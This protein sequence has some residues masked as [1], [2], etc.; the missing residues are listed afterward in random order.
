MKH[1]DDTLAYDDAL[2][3]AALEARRP[4]LIHWAVGHLDRAV[5]LMRALMSSGRLACFEEVLPGVSQSRPSQGEE[6]VWRDGTGSVFLKNN[7]PWE[8]ADLIER[9]MAAGKPVWATL[10]FEPTS[11]SF[12][13]SNWV[14]TQ[15]QDKDREDFEGFWARLIIDAARAEARVM[16]SPIGHLSLVA[17]VSEITPCATWPPLGSK[18][19]RFR[20]S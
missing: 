17:R 3:R 20:T 12:G 11:Q 2:G 13:K 18:P 16:S 9:L 5:I 4:E 1:E 14:S 8:A 10:R 15:F 19:S 7:E 6:I